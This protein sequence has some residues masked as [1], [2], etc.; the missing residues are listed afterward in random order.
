MFLKSFKNKYTLTIYFLKNE[1]FLDMNNQNLSKLIQMSWAYFL[2]WNTEGYIQNI[3]LIQL[4]SCVLL[5]AMP[6]TVARQAP[7]SMG[8]HRQE[9]WSGSPFP[10]TGN[11]LYPGMNLASPAQQTHS[12]LKGHRGRSH[13]EYTRADLNWALTFLRQ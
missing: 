9:S 10:A 5:F 12:L 7:L 6:W 13:T 8:F 11:L 1:A 3:V 4:L 2:R